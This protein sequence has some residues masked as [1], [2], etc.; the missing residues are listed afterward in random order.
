MESEGRGSINSVSWYSTSV[1]R[2]VM[3]CHLLK[4]LEG[5]SRGGGVGGM[6]EKQHVCLD[7]PFWVVYRIPKSNDQTVT[8]ICQF[9]AA[10]KDLD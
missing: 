7:D 3:G 10:K 4:S 2:W 5:G 9:G 8:L 1:S 6:K